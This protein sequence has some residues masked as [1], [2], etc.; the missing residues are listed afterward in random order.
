MIARTETP[1]FFRPRLV[2]ADNRSAQAALTCRQFRRLGWEV[3]LASTG[4]EA[5]R[6]TRLLAPQVVI[7]A[8]ALRDTVVS[9]SAVLAL[10]YLPPLLAQAVSDPSDDTSN[11]SP[12]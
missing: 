3:H 9:I 1:L 6:L 12:P 5:R 8:T 4:P 10:L 11:R 7:L 2:L